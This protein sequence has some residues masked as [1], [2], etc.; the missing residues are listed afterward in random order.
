MEIG[1]LTAVRFEGSPLTRFTICQVPDVLTLSDAMM[2]RALILTD[3][4][5]V[6]GAP[7]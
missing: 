2:M 4:M 3:T 1:A 6:I 5:T 7:S